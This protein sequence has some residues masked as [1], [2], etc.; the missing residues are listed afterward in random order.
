MPYRKIWLVPYTKYNVNLDI[1]SSQRIKSLHSKLKGVEN[2]VIPI[3]KL[4]AILRKQMQELS[5]KQA[6]E[7]FIHQNKYTHDKTNASLEKLRL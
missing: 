5:K 6:Y 7:T 1:R 2:H 3:D 4:F